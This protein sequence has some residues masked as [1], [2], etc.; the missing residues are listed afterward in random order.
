MKHVAVVLGLVA[1]G[2][3]ACTSP[4]FV[5]EPSSVATRSAGPVP[6]L[7]SEHV[8]RG[9]M[10]KTHD[11]SEPDWPTVPRPP[12]GA[13]NIVVIMLD[14][15]GFAA[16]EPF[17]GFASTPT[18][19]G[20]A[21]EGI[22]YNRFHVTAVCSPTRAALMSGRNHHQVGFGGTTEVSSGYPGYN[23]IW[24]KN[25]APVAEV[26]RRRGYSTALFGKWHNT[27]RWEIS[28][29]GPFDRWPTGLGFEQFYGFMTGE[30]SQWEPQLWRN[31]TAVEPPM[32]PE[33]GYHFTTDIAN[34]A[35]GWLH[36][37]EALAPEKPFL[38][39]F[40]PGGPHKPH[41]VPADWIVKYKGL[42][43]A[44]W[45][46]LRIQVLER[47][48][49]LGVVPPD[50]QLAPRAE[51]IPAWDSLGL[52][53]KRLAAHEMETFAG[54]LSHTDHEIGRVIQEIR[55]RPGGEN[56]LIFYLASDNGASGMDGIRGNDDTH[57]AREATEI[58]LSRIAEAAGPLHLNATSA[59]W[60]VMNNTPFPWMK[61]NASHLGGTRVPLVVSWLGRLSDA[62]RV[63]S[64][65]THVTDIAATIY[66]ATGISMPE[67]VDGVAQLPLEGRSLKPTFTDD[68]ARLG[69]RTQYFENWG[70][71]AIYE[72]G[73]MASKRVMTPYQS[74]LAS[75]PNQSANIWELYNLEEDFAQA[76]NVAVQFPEKLRHL[77]DVFDREA[78][79]NNVYP[80]GPSLEQAEATP[81]VLGD[82]TRFTY[83]PDVPALSWMAAPNLAR[84]FRLEARMR[85]P[86]EGV[87]HEGVLATYGSRLGGFSL[88]VE[89]GRVIFENNFAGRQRDRIVAD[90]LLPT[91]SYA[92]VV[93][94]FEGEAAPSTGVR[95][96]GRT[97]YRGTGR[98]LIDGVVVAQGVLP[99]VATPYSGMTTLN[100]GRARN[101]PVS[102]S[103]QLPFAYSGRLERV[104][105]EL[106]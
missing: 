100:V 48:K 25:A 13:P 51:G 60:A 104:D 4:A 69:D 43:D 82:R 76:R 34:E 27:P 61:L 22:S 9:K 81:S 53:D 55:K 54:F 59:G 79:R 14:D 31:T 15:A 78:W 68:A 26:L 2:S 90:R 97:E 47:Q 63:R 96:S 86:K 19:A 36:T 3:V 44:G 67:R 39:F 41:H 72:N 32:T 102:D 80:S 85:T 106:K 93:Y 8:F 42:F 50:T 46:A 84:P 56:T 6:T 75:T 74:Q 28:Q 7:I 57:T 37:Q 23:A 94:E 77:Q 95:R 35:I 88:F 89:E 29:A 1:L 49:R 101:S 5:P 98:L 64:D 91:D 52:E 65:F 38:L 30:T 33:Q 45:D 103:Y 18:L 21:R 99:R 83:H 105:V 40:M 62:G 20:L 87:V 16:S 66:D 12:E 58:Q 17:G 71:V 73:W 70:D 10:G 24:P 11:A 92:S